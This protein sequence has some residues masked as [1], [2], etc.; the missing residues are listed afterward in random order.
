MLGEINFMGLGSK[1]GT[2]RFRN[3]S[4]LFL[5]KKASKYIL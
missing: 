3:V 4:L 1:K 5:Y 2:F